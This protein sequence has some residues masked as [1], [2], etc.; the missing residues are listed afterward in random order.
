MSDAP[1]LFNAPMIRA[2]LAG[3]K[4]ETRRVLKPQPHLVSDGA[5][6]WIGTDGK[7]HVA[8]YR[9]GDRLWV[10]ETWQEFLASELPPDRPRSLRGRFG[11]PSEC[12][13]GNV[14]Y[15]TYRADGEMPPHPEMGEARWRP[16][17]HMPRWAS[18]LTLLVREVR[19]ERLQDI[20]EDGARAEGA[21][22][23]SLRLLCPD[24]AQAAW[25]ERQ[26]FSRLWNHQYG[27][28]A[29]E[30]NPWVT[31]T[32]FDVIRANIDSAECRAAVEAALCP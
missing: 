20:T 21:R 27:P 29:W 2:L 24:L 14:S 6:T 26:V 23:P 4:T 17:I 19:I 12:A 32:G 28:D 9:P 18:R 7:G 10:R 8:R 16:S 22:E 11:I 15:V 25:S 5:A 30:A 13:K 3:E 1:I 31:V